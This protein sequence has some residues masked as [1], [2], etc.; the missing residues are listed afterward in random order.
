[1]VSIAAILGGIVMLSQAE[2]RVIGRFSTPA[3]QAPEPS[4]G[5]PS[6]RNS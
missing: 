4:A 3:P 2:E 6:A 5:N 1:V